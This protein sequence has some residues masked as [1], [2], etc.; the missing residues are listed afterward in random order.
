[1]VPDL[2]EMVGGL[3]L[4]GHHVP[5][6]MAV[7]HLLAQLVVRLSAGSYNVARFAEARA[8]RLWDREAESALFENWK[9]A[10]S[11]A[12]PRRSANRISASDFSATGF[13][14]IPWHNIA[15]VHAPM[16]K[17]ALSA[18]TSFDTGNNSQ[19]TILTVEGEIKTF[20][21][22]AANGPILEKCTREMAG[23]AG[24]DPSADAANASDPLSLV[25]AGRSKS[26]AAGFSMIGL[27][28]G[29]LIAMG[30]LPPGPSNAD[31]GSFQKMF[32]VLGTVGLLGGFWRVIR[33]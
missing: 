5:C 4:D 8:A 15:D 26:R 25:Q 20:R 28:V 3:L 19:L 2:G 31:V 33:P 12:L 17:D 1:L 30:L 11:Q 6:P 27:G 23:M 9:I 16:A 13:A 29:C 21:T 7:A 14:G 10:L 24:S 32:Y 18:L 22:T